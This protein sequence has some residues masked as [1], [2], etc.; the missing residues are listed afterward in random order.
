MTLL[1][2][3]LAT[4]VY[5][6][7]LLLCLF[8]SGCQLGGRDG[9]DTFI[10]FAWPVAAV[11][12]LAVAVVAGALWVLTWR[13]PLH[14]LRHRLWPY[15]CAEEDPVQATLRKGRAPCGATFWR[16]RSCRA[17]MPGLG[18]VGERPWDAPWSAEEDAGPPVLAEDPHRPP[19]SGRWA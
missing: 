7:G 10:A 13:G 19:F 5:G 3:L 6:L 4:A 2:V 15:S 11:V 9:W 8:L 14:P 16:C 12:G 1:E 18:G 17:F